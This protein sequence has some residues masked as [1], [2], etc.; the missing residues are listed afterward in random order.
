[1]V[2]LGGV[3]GARV[4]VRAEG[5]QTVVIGVRGETPQ[6]VGLLQLPAGEARKRK[7]IH[8]FEA[9]FEFYNQLPIITLHLYACTHM[10]GARKVCM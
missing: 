9:S 4:S 6:A 1:M 5:A 2:C 7:G 10:Y 8:V 3:F